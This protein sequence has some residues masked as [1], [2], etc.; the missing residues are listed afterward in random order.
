MSHWKPEGRLREMAPSGLHLLRW[1]W[2]TPFPWGEEGKALLLNCSTAKVIGCHL[3]DWASVMLEPAVLDFVTLTSKLSCQRSPCGKKPST[4][5]NPEPMRQIAVNWISVPPKIP[6]K[7]LSPIR[8][9]QEVE[10]PGE[11]APSYRPTRMNKISVF[12]K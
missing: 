2:I 8:W 3:Q 9:F 12:I 5:F 11:V 1:P 4:A 7:I 10:R 6:S